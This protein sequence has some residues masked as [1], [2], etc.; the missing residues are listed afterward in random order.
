M[1]NKKR[2]LLWVFLLCLGIPGLLSQQSAL[3]VSNQDPGSINSGDQAIQT[4]LQNLGFSVTVKGGPNSP[5]STADANNVDLVLISSTVNS[6]H[7]GN[8]FTQVAVPVIVNESYLLDDMHMTGNAVNHD[9]GV[10]SHAR[11][12]QITMPNHPISQSVNRIFNATSANTD[13]RWGNPSQDADRIARIGTNGNRYGLFVYEAGDNMVGMQAPAMR[14]GFFF[15]N[16]TSTHSTSQA[17]TLFNQTVQ[18][19]TASSNCT[20][21]AGTISIDQD[22]VNLANG[23]AQVSATPDGNIHVPHGYSVIYVLTSGTNLVI[24]QANTSPDFTVNTAGRY[25]IH[26][27]VYDADPHSPDFVDLSLIQFGVT[28]GGDAVNFITQNNICASLDVAGAPVQV[29]A[30][31]ADAGTISIDHDPVQLTNGSATVSATPDGNIH[32]PHGYS[33]LYVLTSGQNLVIEQVSNHPSFTVN[34]AGRYTI[35]TLVYDADPHSPDF[36]DL[37]VVQPGVT[38]GG[39]VLGIVTANGICASLDVAGAPVHVNAACTAD[40]GTITIDQDPVILA[41]GSAMI[42]ATPDG[43]I[44]VPAGYSSIFVLTSGSN[45]VIEAV[46]ATPDFTVNAAGLY[47]IHTLVYDADPNSAD[48]LDL[49][50][51]QFGTTTGGDVLGIVTANG[52]CASLDVAGAP[53]HVNDC[54]ADAGTITIDHDPVHLRNGSAHISATPDGNIHVPGGYSVIYVLTSGQNLVIEAVNT[55]PDFTVNAAGRYTIHTLVYDADPHSP[56]FLDLSVVQFGTT[57]GG[58][59]LGIVTANGIC[60]SLDVAGAPVH[61]NAAC[62]ADAGTLTIDQDPVVLANGSA[63][64]SATPDGNINIPAG[65]SS[66]FVLTSGSNL[67]I[68]AVNATPDFTVNAAGLYTIHT[69]VYDADPNS[70]D[71][72]DLSIVQF[73]TTTGG[74]VLGIVTANGICASLDVAGAPVHVNDCD[75]DAG[76]LTIDQDPVILANGSAQVSA[77]PDGNINIPTGYIGAYVLTSGTNLVIEQV[78]VSPT[79]TVTAAGRY[80]IHTLVF[81]PNPNSP[82]F[83]DLTVVQPGVTTGGDVLGLINAGGICASLDVAGAPVHVNDCTADAGTLTI[84]QDPVVLANGSAMISATPN[85]DINIPTGYSSIF[86]LTSGS[87]LVIEA[88]N[89]TPDFTVNAAGLYTIHTLVYD[90]DPNSPNFLDLGVVQFGT[91]TGGDVL[92]IVTANGICA[93][94]D[95]AGAPVHVNDCTADAGTITIDQDPVVLANGSAMI[96]ATPNGDINIPSGYSSIFVLTSGSNLVIEAVN[97]TPDFTVNAAG[98][99]T[100]HTLVYD[101][102]PNSP[103]FLDLGVVQFGTTTGGD[104]LGIVTANGICASLDVAGA[105][106]HVNDCTADAGTLTI[107]QDPVVLA[108]GSAMIS[109]TPNGDINIPAGYSSIFVLTSGSNLVIEAVNA[110]PDFTV[111]AAGLYTIHT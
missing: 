63:M 70:A 55:T 5:V 92:G 12:M 43:N 38:T 102:D 40:A 26:T 21:D 109:A 24:E 32:V 17:W 57:T 30:C 68:E 34:A 72:L 25:T 22:P 66:I 31:T 79:F 2:L 61:V 110:T 20:A 45:L 50:I 88:V 6:T 56:N 101:A 106:V 103:N 37:S 52:I 15:D 49:S 53:V 99:Y 80:T 36:L 39:D 91:T 111:N 10:A 95:V 13:L 29:N 3:L 41:N 105:P 62:T 93:S 28:T 83:L 44:N 98:L 73:G 19:A 82:N 42:S 77:T 96:S 75:A 33:V 84:D 14:I 8:M 9:Y 60:A 74:D 94:L 11:R 64:I 76:T 27:L 104:V 71:F 47:T 65:Y 58:D 108:N 97:A 35:H 7:I 18:Y 54:T 81:D 23:S 51:V 85:G 100:I 4:A 59:V 89:T 90:A 87:N 69:L 1:L 86:V 78:N 48:F 107:D 46:N 16:L 67:V